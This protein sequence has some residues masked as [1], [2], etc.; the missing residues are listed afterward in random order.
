MEQEWKIYH[1]YPSSVNKA[2]RKQ[3]EDGYVR[4]QTVESS[5]ALSDSVLGWFEEQDDEFLKEYHGRLVKREVHEFPVAR[6][7]TLAKGKIHTE[8]S[9]SMSIIIK[10]DRYLSLYDLLEAY[11]KGTQLVSREEK[12]RNLYQIYEQLAE[13]QDQELKAIRHSLSHPRRT[14]TSKRTVET[15]QSLFGDTKINLQKY[16][17]A[18][19]FREKYR[20]LKDES[21]T[22][23]IEEILKILPSTPNFLGKYYML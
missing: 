4:V 15:L 17:H 3:Y 21:E 1:I 12:Y 16:K 6:A 2:L 10:R 8:S 9:Q 14:L 7:I 11:R 13:E 19:I 23:L 5:M 18:K 22:L 20:Q